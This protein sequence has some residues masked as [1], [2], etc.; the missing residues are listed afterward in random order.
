MQKSSI[1]NFVTLVNPADLLWAVYAM[2]D[3]AWESHYGYPMG[4][5][6]LTRIAN[7]HVHASLR[8]C[9]QVRNQHSYYKEADEVW[10]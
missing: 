9:H 6:G 7:T 4:I 8:F 2:H 1:S 10:S 5:P 3:M